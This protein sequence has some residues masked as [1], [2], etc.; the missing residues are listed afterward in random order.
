MVI[1]FLE[2]LNIAGLNWI[3]RLA[4]E[5]I[6]HFRILTDYRQKKNKPTTGHYRYLFS[7]RRDHKSIFVFFLA[8]EV[9]ALKAT[10][11][12]PV[13]VGFT[14]ANLSQKTR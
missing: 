11:Q 7:E 1:D 14:Y 5:G 10:I 12:F 9:T 3:N 2:T 4:T 6:K 8:C 13:K